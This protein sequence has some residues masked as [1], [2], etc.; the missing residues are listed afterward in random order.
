[1]TGRI[2]AL[3]WVM[4]PLVF[5]RSLQI[6]RLLGAL[7]ACG[8]GSMV[9]T[10]LPA[11]LP[12]ATF[13]MPFA[14]LY[15][16]AYDLL[17]IDVRENVQPSSLGR[18]F[19]RRWRPVP[20]ADA[21]NWQIRAYATLKNVVSSGNYDVLVTFAQPWVNHLIGLR[22]KQRYRQLPWIVHFSDPWVDSPYATYADEQAR[23]RALREE[24]SVIGAADAV[25]FVTERTANLVMAKYPP[26]WRSKVHVVTHGYDERLLAHIVPKQHE[27]DA[28]HV[29]HTGNLYGLRSPD[30]MLAAVERLAEVDG[31]RADLRVEFIGHV[32]DDFRHVVE[33]RGLTDIVHFSGPTTYLES[34]SAAA[35]ADLL[36]V[37]DAP[38]KESVFLPSKL[39]DYLMLGKPILGLTPSNGASADVLRRVGCAVVDP[40]NPGQIADAL[41]RALVNWRTSGRAGPR[42]EPAEAAGFEIAHVAGQFLEVVKGAVANAPARTKVR[43]VRRRFR[44]ARTYVTRT[45]KRGPLDKMSDSE[46]VITNVR[47][48]LA[49]AGTMCT[50]ILRT[51]IDNSAIA[52]ML[53]MEGITSVVLTAPM[54]EVSARYPG[55]IGWYSEDAMAWTLPEQVAADLIYLGGL[56]EFGLRYVLSAWR[57]GARVFRTAMPPSKKSLTLHLGV[58]LYRSLVYR[59]RAMLPARTGV[60]RPSYLRRT[61]QA[62][63][64]T[65][66]PAIPL[67]DAN[68]VL[69]ITGGLGPGGAERQIV[70]TLAGL[71]GVNS[72]RLTL[73]HELG[74]Q[75]PHDFF[76]PEIDQAKVSV[77]PLVPLQLKTRKEWLEQPGFVAL[78]DY[79]AP[80][81]D[82]RNEVV[83][84]AMAIRQL[85][86][87]VVHAW[88]DRINVVAGLA[89]A[90][91]GVPRI[92]LSCRSVAPTHFAFYQSYMHPLYRLLHSLP[93]VTILNNS[94]A[95]ATDYERWLNLPSGSIE[96]VRNGFVFPAHIEREDVVRLGMA[97]RERVGIPAGAVVLGSV[98]RLSEEKRPLLWMQAAERVAR[99]LPDAY[100]LIVGDGPLVD[101]V[102]RYAEKAGLSERVRFIKRESMIEQALS[103]MDLFLLTSRK[104]GLPNVLVEA[105]SLGVPVVTTNAGGASETVVHALTGWVLEQ[106]DCEHIA[107]VIVKLLRDRDWY[108]KARGEA[109]DFV[110]RTFAIERMLDETVAIYNRST[111]SVRSK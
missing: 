57:A 71:S 29:V 34:L 35:G 52:T 24:R 36:L 100:F 110:R 26:A 87:R 54:P 81:G 90:L 65:A 21:D 73:M 42:P 46:R 108:Q 44:A 69:M 41:H 93:N 63:L 15:D 94:Q 22:V 109:P 62:I 55:R 53:Q 104:E 79:L 84:Y 60:L 19:H 61:R 76:L 27:P 31:A 95:G 9:V 28:M 105:Q 17:N 101:D 8:W 67:R 92:V 39:V 7:E 77:E 98:M 2:L 5:P 49:A 58:A 30:V 74:M 50:V 85:R 96:V 4:P 72:G 32:T 59:G 83:A 43:N 106:D 97:Y 48:A 56:S 64:D 16:D 47:S 20:N 80:L 99:K 1:M 25:V 111:S 75:S 82:T 3:S 45:E 13:D 37:L 91:V 14:S 38:A 68:G 107:N 10:Q 102:T 89:A 40:E 86:P 12:H 88:L 18:Q 11:A 103:C 23:E 66:P 33:E 6:S 70:N 78:W 51:K